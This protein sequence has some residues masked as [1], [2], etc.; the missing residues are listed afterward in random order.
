M[1]FIVVCIIIE[2]QKFNSSLWGRPQ[3]LSNQFIIWFCTLAEIVDHQPIQTFMIKKCD[4]FSLWQSR[5]LLYQPDL[6]SSRFVRWATKKNFKTDEQK[7]KIGK[8]MEKLSIL[9]T[10]IHTLQLSCL[11]N[12]ILIYQ[13][14]LRLVTS[15]T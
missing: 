14:I 11:W 2:V 12:S 8:E 5:A 6:N 9:Y 4:F 15:P 3:E 10:I 1:F 7:E 13:C